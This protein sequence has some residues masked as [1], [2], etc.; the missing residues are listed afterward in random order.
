MGDM[1]NITVITFTCQLISLD[2]FQAEL[3]RSPRLEYTHLYFSQIVNTR[4]PA[5]TDKS[6]SHFTSATPKQKSGLA[7]LQNWKKSQIGSEAGN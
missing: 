7:K 5:W 3:T 6:A 1:V 4:P 2:P